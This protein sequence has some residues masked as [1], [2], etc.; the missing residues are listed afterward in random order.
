MAVGARERMQEAGD[1]TVLDLNLA[2]RD[3]VDMVE[4]GVQPPALDNVDGGLQPR[5]S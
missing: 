2:A 1:R 3:P 5:P 4:S